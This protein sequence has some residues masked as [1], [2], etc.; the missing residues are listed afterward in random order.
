MIS[1]LEINSLAA[2]LLDAKAFEDATAFA[3]VSIAQSLAVLVTVLDAL[4]EGVTEH[5][6]GYLMDIRDAL[7]EE[8]IAVTITNKFGDPS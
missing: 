4:T 1:A 6:A 3:A 8:T 5:V 7:M 2:K